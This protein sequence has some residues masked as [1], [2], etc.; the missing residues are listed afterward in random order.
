MNIAE[1]DRT[2]KIPCF[3]NVQINLEAM[4]DNSGHPIEVSNRVF[5]PYWIRINFTFN[6]PTLVLGRPDS[7][8]SSPLIL[9]PLIHCPFS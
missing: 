5:R 8:I 3:I 4:P 1:N 7:N 9:R 6:I 2:W